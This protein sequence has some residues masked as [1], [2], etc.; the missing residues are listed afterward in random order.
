MYDKYSYLFK[1]STKQESCL[2]EKIK[3]FAAY[4]TIVREK[5]SGSHHLHEDPHG[6][7]TY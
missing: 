4:R 3:S 5:K 1:V 2:T 6:I 7:I